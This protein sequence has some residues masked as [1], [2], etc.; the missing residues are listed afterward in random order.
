MKCFDAKGRAVPYPYIP[1]DEHCFHI[2]SKESTP[3]P[4][5]MGERKNRFIKAR[6]VCC[7][8]ERETLITMTEG[9]PAQLGFVVLSEMC[10]EE[11]E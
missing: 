5:C 11:G 4:F 6:A 3:L 7:K 1:C 9:I 2:V 8:C 10:K